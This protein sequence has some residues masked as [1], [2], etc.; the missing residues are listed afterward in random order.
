MRAM[1]GK[2][3][4]GKTRQDKDSAGAAA[5]VVAAA[6]A[7]AVVL[8]VVALCLEQL[9]TEWV[10]HLRVDSGTLGVHKAA[11]SNSSKTGRRNSGQGL[12]GGPTPHGWRGLKGGGAR[13][14]SARSGARAGAGSAPAAGAGTGAG[15]AAQQRRDLM[16]GWNRCR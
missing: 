6:V 16:L 2:A 4:Q 9:A 15:A 3:M 7:A 13:C 10:G 8:C 11:Q 14:I 1:Q 12:I 5:D